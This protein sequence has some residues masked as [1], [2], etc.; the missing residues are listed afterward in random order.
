VSRVEV[1]GEECGPSG[2]EQLKHPVD[3]GDMHC[4]Q[5]TAGKEGEHATKRP[6]CSHRNV[7]GES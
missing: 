1:R 2:V 3:E 5:P 7:I 6:W 4:M